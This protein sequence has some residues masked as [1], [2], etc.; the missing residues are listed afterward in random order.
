MMKCFVVPDSTTN[1]SGPIRSER[2]LASAGGPPRPG[3]LTS[4]NQPPDSADNREDQQ[5]ADKEA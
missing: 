4:D 5:P 3:N 1:G 2:K